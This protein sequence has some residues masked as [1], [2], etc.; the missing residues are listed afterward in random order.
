M[1]KKTVKFMVPRPSYVI[2]SIEHDAW[3]RADAHGY[4]RELA[5]AGTYGKER[6]TVIVKQANLF[7]RLN[8]CMIPYQCVQARRKK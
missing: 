5:E 1:P 7:G 4:T 3:W 8:E 6:A 2:W